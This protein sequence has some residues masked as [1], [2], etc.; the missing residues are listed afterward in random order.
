[1]HIY[2]CDIITPEQAIE[3]YAAVA[4]DRER[5]VRAA[6]SV[7]LDTVYVLSEVQS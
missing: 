5:I 2:L 3:R 7:K 6:N 4:K 1:M